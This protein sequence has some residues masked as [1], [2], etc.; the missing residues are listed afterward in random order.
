MASGGG[1]YQHQRSYAVGNSTLTVRFGDLLESQAEVLVSSDDYLLTMGGGVSA[2]IAR[3]AGN[4]IAIDAAK[5]IPLNLGDVVVTAAGALDAR[6][7]FHVVSIGP[8]ADN[9]FD[10]IEDEPDTDPLEMI[11][12][13]T[14]RCISIA[15]TLGVRSIA[16]P[17]IGAGV[18]A[19]DRA[20]VAAGMAEAIVDALR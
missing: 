3:A 5:A 20:V 11:R 15:A 10:A 6:Y 19:I 12:T 4:A 17:A 1:N 13:A 9:P 8:S 7:V 16:F 14:E 18:A 2:A